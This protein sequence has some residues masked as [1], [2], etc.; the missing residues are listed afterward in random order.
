M[1]YTERIEAAIVLANY[2]GFDNDCI[3]K[4][5]NER[6]HRSITKDTVV[7]TLNNYY[8]NLYKKAEEYDNLNQQNLSEEESV[9][10]FK[11]CEKPEPELF[12]AQKF[13]YDELL[14]GDNDGDHE[15]HH[16]N[17][18]NKYHHLNADS[19]N[20]LFKEMNIY[21]FDIYD[22]LILQSGPNFIQD[23]IERIDIDESCIYTKEF[24]IRFNANKR[25]EYSYIITKMNYDD[26]VYTIKEIW[27][28]ANNTTFKRFF[29]EN[30]DMNTFFFAKQKEEK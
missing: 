13:V 10:D 27:K 5:I 7:E 26:K 3:A 30:V 9:S 17:V 20:H 24:K 25:D 4:N 2:N 12:D 29:V 28:R 16:L 21:D 14:K 6:F 8:N 15:Y 1:T 19:R 18:D 22:M 11:I 23:V